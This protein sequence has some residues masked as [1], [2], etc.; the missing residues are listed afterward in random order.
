MGGK[1]KPEIQHWHPLIWFVKGLNSHQYRPPVMAPVMRSS[2][3]RKG[4]NLHFPDVTC[5]VVCSPEL[6]QRLSKQTKS[7]LWF[8]FLLPPWISEYGLQPKRTAEMYGGWSRFVYKFIWLIICLTPRCDDLLCKFPRTWR[9]TKTC[10]T[11][12]RSR[13][14]VLSHFHTKILNS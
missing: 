2:S 6:F 12:W 4:R 9:L 10:Q 8:W 13:I 7:H 5:V 11:K 14:K 3:H 1:I